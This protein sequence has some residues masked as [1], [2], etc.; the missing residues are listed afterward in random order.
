MDFNRIICLISV[1]CEFWNQAT[2]KEVITSIWMVNIKQTNKIA[3][4][5]L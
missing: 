2:W 3:Q 5:G 4:N 1:F